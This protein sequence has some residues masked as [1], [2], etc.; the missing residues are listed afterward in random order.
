ME[1]IDR[2]FG[3]AN[4]RHHRFPSPE[5]VMGLVI[6]TC[7]DARIDPH[8]LLGVGL[9]DAHIIRNAGGMVTDDVV[10]SIAISQRLVGTSRIMVVHHTNCLA[11]GE[12]APG[13]SPYQTA[14]WVVGQ[15]RN[16]PRLPY[17][18]KIR[19]FVL[20]TANEGE[21]TLTEA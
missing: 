4:E 21:Q 2:L 7:M 18:D 1:K 3:M 9:G 19:G 6:L 13:Y 8:E 14:R 5:P 15:L 16:D 11:H 20:D 10:E 12:R 17:R